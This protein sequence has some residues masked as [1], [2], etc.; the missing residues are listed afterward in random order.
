MAIFISFSI[1]WPMQQNVQPM[2]KRDKCVNQA[3]SHGRQE[4]CASA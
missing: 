2:K 3:S 4:H 1:V